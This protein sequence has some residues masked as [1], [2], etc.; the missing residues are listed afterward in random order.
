MDAAYT[1]I[2]NNVMAARLGQSLI[3]ELNTLASRWN[4]PPG[5]QFSGWYQYFDRDVRALLAKGKRLPDQ[6]N[7]T[8]CGKGRLGLCRSQVWT[9]IQAAGDQLTAEHGTPD[10]AAWRASATD[11][12]INFSPLPLIT[13]RYTNRPSG[14]QQVI[15]FKK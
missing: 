1:F 4:A 5:G 10:P 15:S 7:L 9:A 12:D 13:M 6:F 11:E 3:T 2:V 8:Y 14:I